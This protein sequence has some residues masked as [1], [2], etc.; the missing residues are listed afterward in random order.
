[1]IT[2]NANALPPAESPAQTFQR[3]YEQ[4][5]NEEKAENYEEHST[6]SLCL[7]CRFGFAVACS[8]S[9]Y[10]PQPHLEV[11]CAAPWFQQP[12]HFKNVKN[13]NG[14]VLGAF[15]SNAYLNE[16]Y[17]LE[18]ALSSL[19][20][21]DDKPDNRTGEDVQKSGCDAPLQRIGQDAHTVEEPVAKGVIKKG[22]GE[23]PSLFG[24][25]E[26]EED[27]KKAF[28][29]DADDAKDKKEAQEDGDAP[30]GAP[31]SATPE[32]EEGEEEEGEED[33]DAEEDDK[34]KK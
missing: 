11:M 18:K 22:Q 6:E 20:S 9:E 5:E 32:P 23:Q 16:E 2:L 15:D 1:M 25:A 10:S 14:F 27:V 4:H 19:E 8:K 24:K 26:E 17:A 3:D 13:C 7:S 34:D 21:E 33:E 31:P 30:G 29:P 12:F 28:P